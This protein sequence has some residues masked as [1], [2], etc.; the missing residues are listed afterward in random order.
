MVAA[1][2]KGALPL[3]ALLI[4]H[5]PQFLSENLHSVRFVEDHSRHG[6]PIWHQVRL[7]RVAGREYHWNVGFY[8]AH[9]GIRL[10]AIQSRHHHIHENQID[11]FVNVF[12]DPDCL[13]SILRQHHL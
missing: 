7:R 2:G 13:G 3:F 10:W 6:Q 5:G 11:S 4:Q 9:L 12:E 8:P 1:S